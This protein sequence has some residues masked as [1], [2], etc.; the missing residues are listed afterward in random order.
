MD[1]SPNGAVTGQIGAGVRDVLTAALEQDDLL[2]TVLVLL[3]LIVIA[4]GALY[5][6]GQTVSIIVTN[7]AENFHIVGKVTVIVP[8]ALIAL[9]LAAERVPGQVSFI[10]SLIFSTFLIGYGINKLGEQAEEV[11]SV[12]SE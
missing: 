3:A 4:V 7:I 9:Y 12:S 5:F 1:G 6:Q 2:I 11:T 8:F 10:F